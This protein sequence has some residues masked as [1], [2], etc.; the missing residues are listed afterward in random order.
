MRTLRRFAGLS[1]VLLLSLPALRGAEAATPDPGAYITGLGRQVID[2]MADSKRPEP[3]RERAFRDIAEH[4]FDVPKISR[5]TLGRYWAAASETER[6]QFVATFEDYMIQVYWSYFKQYRAEAITLVAQRNE[7]N[8]SVRVST[9][10]VRPAG[11]TPVK[12]DW[13]ITAQGDG[14]KILDVSIEGV[15]QALTYREEFASIINRNGG[16]VAAVIDELH[17]KSGH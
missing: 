4:A 9:E 16:G 2:L 15:S 11:Q 10:I 13:T 14:Y 12:V 5:F 17:R 6:Q 7:G 3:E 8:N 1:F